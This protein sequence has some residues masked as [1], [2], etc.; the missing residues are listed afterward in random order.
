MPTTSMSSGTTTGLD[1][2]FDIIKTDKSTLQEYPNT[3]KGVQGKSRRIAPSICV[4]ADIV[5]VYR[6]QSTANG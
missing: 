2:Q 4:K 1:Q 5:S 3:E 6:K